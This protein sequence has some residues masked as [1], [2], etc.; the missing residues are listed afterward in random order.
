MIRVQWQ[1]RKVLGHR[2]GLVD[3]LCPSDLPTSGDL[4]VNY[5][6]KARHRELFK[7]RYNMKFKQLSQMELLESFLD[8]LQRHNGLGQEIWMVRLWS[9][10]SRKY[11]VLEYPCDIFG[12]STMRCTEKDD[13][14][15]GI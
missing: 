6:A 8:G 4:P 10:S 11:S 3:N 2:R 14:Q 5:Q 13:S 7:E 9:S 1:A 15:G 12:L